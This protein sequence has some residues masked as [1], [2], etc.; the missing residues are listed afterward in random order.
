[1]K[2][3][4]PA[5]L[6]VNGYNRSLCA[7]G[8]KFNWNKKLQQDFSGAVAGKAI[9]KEKIVHSNFEF[10]CILVKLL[11]VFSGLISLYYFGRVVERYMIGFDWSAELIGV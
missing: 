8:A 9:G 10:V 11:Q 2:I 6:L 4:I 3:G 1:M 7:C 5:I